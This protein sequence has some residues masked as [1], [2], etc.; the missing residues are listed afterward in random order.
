MSSFSAGDITTV[1][2]REK[3]GQYLWTGRYAATFDGI[4]GGGATGVK[5]MKNCG[6]NKQQ[7]GCSPLVVDSPECGLVEL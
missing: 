5:S 2:A 1:Y 7:H 4:G 3:Q 6:V